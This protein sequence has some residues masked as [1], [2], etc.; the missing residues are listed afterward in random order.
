MTLF[1]LRENTPMTTTSRSSRVVRCS[2]CLLGAAGVLAGCAT[3]EKSVYERH[4]NA[5]VKATPT[6]S[7]SSVFISASILEDEAPD[8]SAVE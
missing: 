8:P 1:E 7:A 3:S 2:L 4:L 5:T 6:S